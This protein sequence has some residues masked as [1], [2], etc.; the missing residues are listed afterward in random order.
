MLCSVKTMD[1]A[2]HDHFPKRL[3][4]TVE[5]LICGKC[6]DVYGNV[7]ELICG[8]NHLKSSDQLIKELAHACNL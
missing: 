4:N 3:S 8:E 1:F 2:F 5:C 6:L 7:G